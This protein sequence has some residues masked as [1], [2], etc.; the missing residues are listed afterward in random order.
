ME[1]RKMMVLRGLL[2]GGGTVSYTISGTVYD[3]DGSTPVEGATVA[4]GA[5]SAESAANGTYTINSIP[6]GTSGSMTCTKAGYSWTAI[7]VS[8]MSGNLTGQDYD[9][10]WWATGGI[11]ASCVGAYRG[12]GAASYAASL[13]NL[14]NPGTNDLI[15]TGHVPGWAAA[16]GW[17]GASGKYLATGIS[18]VG[19][20]WTMIARIGDGADVGTSLVMGNVAAGKYFGMLNTNGTQHSICNALVNTVG[21]RVLTG[22]LAVA[23]RNTFLDGV[24]DGTLGVDAATS[25]EMYLL[26]INTLAGFLNGNLY[27]AA[28]Y[29]SVLS[30]V[31]ALTTAMAALT[32]P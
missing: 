28:L 19:Q 9:N 24:A 11:G 22:V 32:N 6:P 4:L 31:P 20:G 16:T 23:G 29:N 12:L 17:V 8:A 13:I 14:A 15:D 7:T 1:K 10:A 27:A 3:A 21:A 25:G 30:N 26:A 18:G 5:L 2:G